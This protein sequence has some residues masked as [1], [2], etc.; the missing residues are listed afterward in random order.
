MK[1]EIYFTKIPL[2]NPYYLAF[3]KVEFLDAVYCMVEKNGEQHWGETTPLPGYSWETVESIKRDLN[4]VLQN[5]RNES[6][7]KQAIQTKKVSSPF[8][9]SCINIALEKHKLQNDPKSVRVPLVGIISS[10]DEREIEQQLGEQ[11][12]LGFS[13]IKVKAQGTLSKDVEKVEFIQ[14]ILPPCVKIRIDANQGFAL[15]DAP[16]F[17]SIL[18]P[19]K[20]ELFEQ[21]YSPENWKEMAELNAS[22]S[23]P[24]MLDESIWTKE[25]IDRTVNEG[26]AS[27]VKLKLQKHASIKETKELIAYARANGLGVVFGN[28]VQS[29]LGCFDE[30]LIADE[31]NLTRPLELNGFLKHK[32]F[33][34]GLIRF[35]DGFATTSIEKVFSKED[36]EPYMLTQIETSLDNS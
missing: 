29:E 14:R 36:I 30:A 25:H 32:P 28:G 10:S 12:E 9:M 5:S 26:C 19:D 34:T 11:L 13:I 7:L 2:L 27:L 8:A 21:P 3:Q 15:D 16:H 33:D 4:E 23:I 20:V 22:S 31:C 1:L 35:Q 24:L 18:D 17:L 6:D